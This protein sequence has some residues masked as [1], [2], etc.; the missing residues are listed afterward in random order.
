M[1]LEE[2]L[3]KQNKNELYDLYYRV[4]PN[5]QKYST[6]TKGK[7]KLA[8]RQEYSNYNTIIEICTLKELK[9][10]KILV[11]NNNQIPYDSKYDWEIKNL[12]EKLIINFQNNNIVILED[13]YNITSEAVN[14]VN[15]HY[16][17]QTNKLNE[18]LIGICKTYIEIPVSTFNKIAST[19]TKLTIEEIE[20]YYQTNKLFNYYVAQENASLIYKNY[21]HFVPELLELRRTT[22]HQTSYNLNE[23]DYISIFYNE[24]NL[25]NPQINKLYQELKKLPHSKF[26]KDMIVAN[27]ILNKE[28]DTLYSFIKEMYKTK[29]SNI[30]EFIN[31]LDLAMN[32]IPSAVLIEQPK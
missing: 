15:W 7:M 24:L 9:Y 32:E 20:K 1:K 12:K 17:E 5:A 31:L 2:I 19:I 3:N 18:L 10:L 4:L 25:N 13:L 14:K 29:I 28:R 16:Q 26:L 23:K 27:V 21:Y 11:S 22:T 6:I 8:I 30:D